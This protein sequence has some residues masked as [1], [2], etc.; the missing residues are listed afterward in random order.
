MHRL[1]L[2]PQPRFFIPCQLHAPEYHVF[3]FKQ[4]LST[5]TLGEPAVRLATE[6]PKRN[7]IQHVL[8]ETVS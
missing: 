8:N 2:I 4:R 3:I 5:I 7:Y 6:I 1:V